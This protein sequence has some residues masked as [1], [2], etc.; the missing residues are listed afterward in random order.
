MM[1]LFLILFA[2]LGLS[3]FAADEEVSKI[4]RSVKERKEALKAFTSAVSL[5]NK[6]EP[7]DYECFSSEVLT[8][9]KGHTEDITSAR[10][11]LDP[12]YQR[13]I[14]EGSPACE[15]VCQETMLAHHVYLFL[16]YLKSYSDREKEN[17]RVLPFPTVTSTRVRAYMDLSAFHSLEKHRIHLEDLFK[18]KV[19]LEKVTLPKLKDTQFYKNSF[20]LLSAGEVFKNSV[21][22]RLGNDDPVAVEIRTDKKYGEWLRRFDEKAKAKCAD[23]TPLD[24]RGTDSATRE[25]FQ[26]IHN[27]KMSKLKCDPGNFG[28][29]RGHLRGMGI[30]YAEDVQKVAAWMKE[31]T[32]KSKATPCDETCEAQILVRTIQTWVTYFSQFER[33][34]LASTMD[35]KLYPEARFHT[36]TE[37]V[38]LFETIREIFSPLVTR[39]GSIDPA[40]ISESG[41]KSEMKSV[42]KDLSF[43]AS[44]EILKDSVICAMKPWNASYDRFMVPY[45]DKE[46]NKKFEAAFLEFQES[47]C[48]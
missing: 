23:T 12:F 22:C 34:A 31:F 11:I 13:S 21:L 26:K 47:L 37:D 18:N 46:K 20:E 43:Y 29:A 10:S 45:P 41:L 16:T 38:I 1:K 9:V 24:Y 39:F 8:L 3:T 4:V 33:K 35:W 6:C 17:S 25:Y 15:I 27:E 40:K 30:R 44:A 7:R 48:K 36:I 28:C 32:E 14:N 42:G 5:G 2:L 19:K